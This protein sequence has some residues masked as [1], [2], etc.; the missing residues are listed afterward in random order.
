M[1]LGL[2]RSPSPV[3]VR[4]ARCSPSTVWTPPASASCAGGLGVPE[5]QRGGLSAEPGLVAG[6]SRARGTHSLPWAVEGLVPKA[7]AAAGG[8]RE[9]SGGLGGRRRNSGSTRSSF[10]SS[11]RWSSARLL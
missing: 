4:S 3:S 2:L 5:A 10:L 11:P 9:G 8:D 6:L 1:L 7:L